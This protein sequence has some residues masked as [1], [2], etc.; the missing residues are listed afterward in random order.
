MILWVP[1]TQPAF[2]LQVM[3][4][5]GLLN[6]TVWHNLTPL[7]PTSG[8]EGRFIDEETEPPGASFNHSVYPSL[9]W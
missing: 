5:H 8:R 6:P 2:F 1:L 3:S 7:T 9:S 4:H